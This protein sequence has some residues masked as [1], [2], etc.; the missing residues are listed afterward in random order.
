MTAHGA[1]DRIH[2]VTPPGWFVGQ[3]VYDPG[4]RQ[5]VQYAYD[6][7]E[8]PKVGLRSREWTA[9]AE[10]ELAVLEEMGRCLAAISEGRVPR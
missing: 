7:R 9:V 1:W 2:T 10:T 6:P 5:F 8:K 3:P 4:R